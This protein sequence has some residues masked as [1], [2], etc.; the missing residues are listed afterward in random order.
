MKKILA[1][2]LENSC[3]KSC[4]DRTQNIKLWHKGNASW[5]DQTLKREFM[6]QRKGIV[7][8]FNIKEEN[9]GT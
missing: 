1:K 5:D 7:A 2:P 8:R 6:A 4:H 3:P 9:S